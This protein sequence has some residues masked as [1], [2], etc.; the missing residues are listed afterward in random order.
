M[1]SVPPTTKAANLGRTL[2]ACFPAVLVMKSAFSPVR[3][4]PSWFE[5]PSDR[6]RPLLRRQM[7][8]ISDSEAGIGLRQRRAGCGGLAVRGGG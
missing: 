2:R 1:E 4:E 8:A 5:R 6:G 7:L 3:S